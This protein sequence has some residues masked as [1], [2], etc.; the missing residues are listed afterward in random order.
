MADEAWRLGGN[1]PARE[2][3]PHR[4]GRRDRQAQRRRCG[5]PR[6]WV[7]CRE[8]GLCRGLRR[9]RPD[10][11]RPD[12]R[13]DPRDGQ[14]DGRT[15][16]G[17]GRRRGGRAWHR[18]AAG[19]GLSRRG[20]HPGGAGCGLSAHVE[21]GGRR[22]WQGHAPRHGGER[23]ADSLRVRPAVEAQ[24]SFGDSSVYLERRLERPRHV[25]VQLL[26]DAHGT[27]LPF[28][29]RECSIQRRHQKVL[30]ESPSVAVTPDQRRALT[31]AAARVARRVGYTNAGTI[32]F[33]LDADGQFYFLEMN[34][35]LQV[36]HPVTE[37][38]TGIDLVS[39]SCASRRASHSP[40]IPRRSSRRAAT[41]SR[42]AS[43]RRTPTIAS[44]PRQDTSRTSARRPAPACATM[45]VLTAPGECPSTTIR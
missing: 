18:G 27:V 16:R 29:E 10:V 21:G 38:V 41:P 13:R 15:C 43:T 4:R 30:E 28:V 20:G 34:T 40:S 9:R 42:L 12:A 23:V 31:D 1:T 5:P 22:R 6:L 7:P 2:L 19:G 26:G 45:A 44:C 33:L 14:Q 17:D 25:E 39:G 36:E 32:E 24:S 8:R 35:R 3:S 37:M 11:H